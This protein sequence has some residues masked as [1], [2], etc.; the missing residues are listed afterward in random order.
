MA[1]KAN[2]TI[3]KIAIKIIAH[4][5]NNE[6]NTRL[7]CASYLSLIHSNL[8]YLHRSI[9]TLLALLVYQLNEI[10]PMYSWYQTIDCIIGNRF[11]FIILF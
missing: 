11:I 10:N 6:G 1:F 4:T 3:S 7:Q 2:N 9:G 8:E 5:Q